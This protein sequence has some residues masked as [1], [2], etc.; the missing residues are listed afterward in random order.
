[1]ETQKKDKFKYKA[2]ISYSARDRK[3]A[4]WLFHQVE[5]NRVPGKVRGTAGR[6]GPVAAR[7][8]P[9]FKDREELPASED[10]GKQLELALEDSACL[11]VVCS[12]RSA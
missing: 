12:P 5:T 10:L 4:D 1:M 7:L 6:D 3:F 2:F 8:Y 9:I 11:V